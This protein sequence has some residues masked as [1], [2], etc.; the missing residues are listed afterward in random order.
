LLCAVLVAAAVAVG[1]ASIMHGGT[2]SVG[3]SSVPTDAQVTVNGVDLGHTPV[4]AELSRKEQHF[5]T[6]RLDGYMPYET[7]LTKTVSGWVWGNIV[8]GGLIGLAVDAISGGL[9]NLTPDQI[10]AELKEQHSGCPQCDEGI[11]IV[12]VLR[13]DPD[14]QRIGTLEVDPLR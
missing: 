4:I 6:I 11:V 10:A 14:W 1:C 2:Q 3:I 12:A 7:T 13:A 9:Y 5:V 8:F